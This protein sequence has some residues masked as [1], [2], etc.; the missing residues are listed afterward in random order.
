MLDPNSGELLDNRALGGMG[1][2]AL[3]PGVDNE[4]IIIGNFFTG[5]IVKY[6]LASSEVT[7]RNNIGQ[8][9]SLSGI[10]QF[11]GLAE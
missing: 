2:A 8:K 6:H 7:T 4:H 3:A 10:A 5:E 11:S 9:N 1:W